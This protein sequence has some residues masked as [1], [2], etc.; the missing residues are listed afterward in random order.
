M[1]ASLLEMFPALAAYLLFIVAVLGA[2]MGSFMNC[3]A[4]RVTVGMSVLRGRSHCP[5][6]NAEL[7]ALDLIPVVSWIA[8]RGACRHCSERISP[9]YVI[10]ELVMMMVFVLLALRYGFTV[11]TLAYAALACILCGVTLV[12]FDTYTIPNGF[13]LAGIGLWA[14]SVWFIEAPAVGFGIGSAFAGA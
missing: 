12:D 2:C 10:V 6:C 14:T 4:W 7:T 9:R 5:H 8:L 1:S 13:I 3:L 11:Q